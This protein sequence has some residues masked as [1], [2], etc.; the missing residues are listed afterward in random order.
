MQGLSAG[1]V[2]RGVRATCVRVQVWHMVFHPAGNAGLATVLAAPRYTF[3]HQV[4]V[5]MCVF[6]CARVCV[7]WWGGCH[8][9][10]PVADVLQPHPARVS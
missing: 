3:I 5:C 2:P 1:A 8:H 7:W 10:H 4:C 9:G 6:V